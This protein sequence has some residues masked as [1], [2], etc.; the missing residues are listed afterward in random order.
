MRTNSLQINSK[1]IPFYQ[2]DINEQTNLRFN[3]TELL[4]QLESNHLNNEEKKYLHVLVKNNSDLFFREGNILT[5]VNS[6]KHQIITKHGLPVYSK[7]YRFPKVHELE[8]EKQVTDMLKQGIIKPSSSAYNSPIWVVPKK[9]DNS[10][11]KKWRIVIDYRKLNEI[12]IDDKFPIPNID[13]LFDKLGR[14]QYFTTLDLAK[15]F[16]QILVDEKDRNKTAFSTPQG[17]Y[18]FVRMP[19]GLKNAPATFQRM[20]NHVL[21]EYINKICVVYLDDILI[22]S[23]SIQEHIDSI[24]KIFKKLR[25]ANLK[26]QVDKCKFFSKETEYLG[27][28]LTNEGIKPNN[29]KIEIIKNLNIP[30]T[31]KEIKSFIGLTGYY[32]KFIKDYAKVVQPMTFCL[33][34]TSIIDIHNSKYVDAFNKLKLLITEHPVLQYPNFNKKFVLTTDASQYA[35][36]AVLSQEGHPISFASRTLNEH[37]IRYS[38]IEKELLA[39]IWATKYYRPY[40][41]GVKFLIQTDHRPLKWLDSLKE[42]NSKLQR[43]RIK[44]NEYDYEI[45]YVRGKDNNV[46]DFLSRLEIHHNDNETDMATIHSAIEDV[47]DH[48][49]IAD[50]IVNT[51]RTQIHLVENKNHEITSKYKVVRQ[52]LISKKDLRNDNYLN[53]V[54]RRFVTK[55]VIGIYSE[56]NDSEYN[57]LQNKLIELFSNDKQIKFVKCAFRATDLVSEDKAIETIEKIHLD[58]NHRGIIENYQELRFV[59]YYPKIKELIHKFINNC[60][61][62]NLAKYDRQPLKPKY[63]ISETPTKPNEIVH[64]DLFI[65]RKKVY[66]TTIDK[67][68]KHLMAIQINDRNYVTLINA[69]QQRFSAFGKPEKIVLD[70]EFN[71]LNVREYF[72]KENIIVHFTSPRSHTGNSD[73]ERVHGTLNEH[74]RLATLNKNDDINDIVLKSVEFYNNTIHSITQVKPNDFVTNKI[75]PNDLNKIIEKMKNNK[76]KI[77]SKLNKNRVEI[78]IPKVNEV[79]VDNPDIIRHKEQP[80]YKKIKTT[81]LNKKLLDIKNRNVHPSRLKRKYKYFSDSNNGNYATIII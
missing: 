73:I 36:G 34:K 56:L 74:I 41:Y 15:G 40:L 65:S 4:N 63:E 61:I 66:L 72:R 47:G 50:R 2:E 62:C 18:E 6:V 57:I 39:I 75:N 5:N 53:D 80:K 45:D 25:E 67:F 14:S 11:V 33:K 51:Y 44:L 43:W 24:D 77:I 64:G 28:V 58:S 19:F 1:T 26:I 46:A 10:N 35:L 37:E 8:V 13:S 22:F 48:I 23:T 69:F 71:S 9:S 27:H 59:H 79:L 32:R 55:G 78:C 81:Y 70:N 38:T 7:I 52:L 42:P 16:H 3:Y 76:E 60:E 12:T 20:M 30:K 54:L 29:K 17:H 49:P 21:R 31:K 68:T